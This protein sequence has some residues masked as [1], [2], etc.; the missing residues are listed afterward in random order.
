MLS[1]ASSLPSSPR[2]PPRLLPILNMRRI[3]FQPLVHGPVKYHEIPLNVANHL[4][5]GLPGQ[6]TG[7]GDQ[8]SGLRGNQGFLDSRGKGLGIAGPLNADDPEGIHHAGHGPQQPQKGC[9]SSQHQN[10]GPCAG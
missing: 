8:E 3:P 10:G 4:T 2:L 5:Q 9:N 1:S 7:N 6:K